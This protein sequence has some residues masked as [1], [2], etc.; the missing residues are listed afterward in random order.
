MTPRWVA[1]ARGTFYGM[2]TSHTKAHFAR[3]VLEGTAFA[4]RDVLDRLVEMGV[5]VEAIRLMGGGSASVV[6][7]QIRADLMGLSMD[8]LVQD[9]AAAIGAAVIAAVAGGGWPDC[10]SASAALALPMLR[11]Q[12]NLAMRDVYDGAYQRYRQLFTALE[13]MFG[14]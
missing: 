1:S 11:V 6:W 14:T 10:R 8:T 2:T 12:P 7:A 13:P 5:G 9:G 3:A 4:M